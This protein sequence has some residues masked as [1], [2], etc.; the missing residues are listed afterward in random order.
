MSLLFLSAVQISGGSILQAIIWF[1]V[2]GLIFWL[3]KWALGEIGLPEPF[4]KVA[5][6]LL[7]LI[8]LVLCINALLMIAGVPFLRLG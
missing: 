6:V 2:A 4:N 5:N 8:V 1:A 7:I 3:C